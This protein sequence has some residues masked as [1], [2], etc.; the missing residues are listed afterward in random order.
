[1]LQIFLCPLVTNI[2]NEL[3]CLSLASLFSLVLYLCLKPVDYLRMEHL[4]E[5]LVWEAPALLANNRLGCKESVKT[6]LLRVFKN[7]GR[8]FS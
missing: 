8:K 6:I 5:A 1:M 4:K 2:F 3:E 7:Y